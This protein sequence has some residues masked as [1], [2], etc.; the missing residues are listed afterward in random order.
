MFII[1]ILKVTIN[2]INTKY[3]VSCFSGK[4]MRHI[5]MKK[6]NGKLHYIPSSFCPITFIIVYILY[7]NDAG[8]SVAGWA[9]LQRL[10]P[11][12]GCSPLFKKFTHPRYSTALPSLPKRKKCLTWFGKEV[13]KGVGLAALIQFR[14]L[15][16]TVEAQVVYAKT[17][18]TA[19]GGVEQGTLGNGGRPDGSWVMKQWQERQNALWGRRVPG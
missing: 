1:T 15:R 9:P 18:L 4:Y 19:N 13:D 12:T 6:N 10:E 7:S 2:I 5:H 11:T 14:Q 3:F 8:L 17:P 16:A